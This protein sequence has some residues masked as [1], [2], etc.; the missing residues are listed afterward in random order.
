MDPAMR[1]TILILLVMLVGCK[2]AT[3]ADTDAAPD[4]LA[5]DAVD[6]AGDVSPAGWQTTLKLSSGVSLFY[7]QGIA[8]LPNGWAFSAKAG[9]WRTDEQFQQLVEK[10]NPLPQAL[11]DQGYGHIGD[12]DMADGKLY[13]GLEQGDDN[14]VKQAVAWFD[15]LTLEFLGSQDLPQHENPCLCIDEATLIAYTPDRYHGTEIRRYDVKNGW[16]PL[17]SLTLSRKL[18]A[19]QG[20]D[21]ANGALWFSCDDEVHGLYRADLLTGETV[22]IGTI[23]RLAAIGTTLPE[24]EGIDASQTATGFL[25]T[26]TN[27]PLQAT[28]WVDEWMLAGP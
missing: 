3:V 16:K 21:A 2:A 28:S 19:M 15:P 25:H 13:A 4:V 18:D 17:P 10:V 20:V 9:L 27:E 12:I 6:A 23:G 22:Q 7:S 1:C 14:L 11:L 24:V 8:R 26:L 5:N